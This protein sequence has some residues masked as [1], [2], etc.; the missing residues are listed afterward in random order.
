[1]ESLQQEGLKCTCL[2]LIAH[3][4]KPTIIIIIGLVMITIDTGIIPIQELK[5]SSL[6]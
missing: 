5:N 6:E 4:N 3:V 2:E 1:M